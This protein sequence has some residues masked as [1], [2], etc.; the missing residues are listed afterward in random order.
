MYLTGAASR[1]PAEPRVWLKLGT[2]SKPYVNF[3]MPCGRG[4]RQLVLN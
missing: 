2:G 1:G 4:E 3:V